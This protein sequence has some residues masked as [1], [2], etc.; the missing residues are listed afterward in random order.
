[1]ISLVYLSIARQ[2]FS[3]QALVELLAVSRRNNARDGITGLLLYK[4]GEFIQVLE[5][6][7]D[8]V[9][10]LTE[11]LE[12]DPRHGQIQILLQSPLRQRQFADWSMG[13]HQLDGNHD[14]D[15]PGF[16]TFLQTP[17]TAQGLAERA[18]L[19]QRL[20]LNFKKVARA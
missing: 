19:V 7:V 1:M 5:G 18:T 4:G 15:I 9:V 14:L 11:K 12:H 13:F 17:A 20:L 10:A 6:P 2:P 3:E 8:P 16:S